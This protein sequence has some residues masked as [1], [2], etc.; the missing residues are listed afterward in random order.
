MT[1]APDL[2]LEARAQQ[3][4]GASDDA[5]YAA[6]ADALRRRGA[7][8][9]IVDVGCGAGRLRT[10]LGDI[11]ESYAGVDAIRYEG[12]P[13]WDGLHAGGFESRS[14]P[15]SGSMADVA[16]SLETIEHLENP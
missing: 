12:L 3:S 11:I 7:R 5:I 2:A 4:L 16:I 15:G 13:Q 1:I 6:A 8:G 10:F 9:R 14:Y